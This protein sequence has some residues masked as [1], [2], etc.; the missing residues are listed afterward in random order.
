[1]ASVINTN[2][3]SLNAQRHLASTQSDMATTIQ[4]LS[5]GL[6]IN[7]AKDD[8][9]GLAV[10]EG[11]TSQIRGLAVATRN[12]NDGISLAQTAE[13]A[14]GQVTDSLQ[15]MRE[16]AVQ[17]AN[18]A[19]GDK[20]RMHLQK[21]MDQLTAEVVRIVDTTEFNGQ[22]LLDAAGGATTDLNIQVGP[23]GTDQ[24]A[25]KLDGMKNATGLLNTGA[26]G[27]NV[28]YAAKN[29]AAAAS[30]LGTPVPTVSL[31]ITTAG[32]ATT[33]IANLDS[34]LNVTVAARATLGAVQNRFESVISNLTNYSENLQA[35]RSR[36]MDTDFAAETAAMTRNQIL[37]Q[38][39]TSMVAQ[40]NQ[41]PQGVLSLLG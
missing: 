40:A 4:R 9:A 41:V 27:L 21:E 29:L 11:M 17:S 16:L 19:L 34:D 5:S 32:G 8:A 23:N 15:R 28:Y 14:L 12:A 18:E 36:I 7:S 33:A 22:S 30:G 20:E 10:A 24:I 38:A 13:G 25:I 6:R 37:S 31:D 2:V 26:N 39:G 35:A 1:M 3:M